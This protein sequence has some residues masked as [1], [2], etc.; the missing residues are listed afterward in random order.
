MRSIE[1]HIEPNCI[2]HTYSHLGLINK[3]QHLNPPTLDELRKDF[4]DVDSAEEADAVAV[5]SLWA[6]T[7]TILHLAVIDEKNGEMVWERK[8][9]GHPV[10]HTALQESLELFAGDFHDRRVLFLRKRF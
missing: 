5:V 3:E 10:K 1:Y 9:E 7:M 2:G 6:G 4:E 8:A